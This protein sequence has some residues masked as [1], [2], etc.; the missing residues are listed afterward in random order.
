MIKLVLSDMDDTLIAYGRPVT[1]HALDAIHAVQDAGIHFGAATGRVQEVLRGM[2]E[3]DERAVATGVF[4]NGQMVSLD[5]RAIVDRPLDNE[6]LRHIVALLAD[7]PDA[8]LTLYEGDESYAVGMTAE[9]REAASAVFWKETGIRDVV[10]SR[11]LYKANIHV[12]GDRVRLDEVRSLIQESVDVFDYV[13]PSPTKPLIDIQPAGVSK[14][15]GADV[16]RQELGL[17]WDE[18]LA[19]GDSENDLELLRATPHAIAV[20]NATPAV[21]AVAAK[22]I[23]STQDDAVAD[24]LFELACTGKSVDLPT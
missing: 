1:Q 10:P 21:K 11:P 6:A 5:G 12:N 4:C 7:A 24:A 18:V 20:A 2:L 19:F 16:L 23:G 3:H 14:A 17:A 8:A 9:E 13:Y 22:V 15:W